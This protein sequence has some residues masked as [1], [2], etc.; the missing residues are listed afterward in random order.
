MIAESTLNKGMLEV[1]FEIEE[2]YPGTLYEDTCLTGL[3]MEFSGRYA[4]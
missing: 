1:C 2:V 3:V 4:H